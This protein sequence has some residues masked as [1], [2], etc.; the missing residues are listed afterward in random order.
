VR[1]T[2][3]CLFHIPLNFGGVMA[4]NMEK[5]ETAG[6]KTP[7]CIVLSD[8]CSLWI[9][10]IYISVSGELPGADNMQLSGRFMSRVF[11]GHYRHVGE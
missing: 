5:I 7:K 9:S 4:R 1:D 3:R 2:V 11:Q 10:V 8:E 6:V